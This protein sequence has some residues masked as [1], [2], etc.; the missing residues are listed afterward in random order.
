MTFILCCPLGTADA[1][2]PPL[3]PPAITTG[4]WID[5]SGAYASW[6]AAVDFCIAQGGVDLCPYEVYCPDGAGTAPFN[7][8]RVGRTGDDQW[9]PF[10]GD[11]ENRWVQTGVWGGDNGNT[12]LGHHQIQGGA[13]G[14]PGWGTGN[15]GVA[16]AGYLD[17]VLCCGE[18]ATDP[19]WFDGEE[20]AW[21]GTTWGAGIDFCALKL[22]S[23]ALSYYHVSCF[24][25]C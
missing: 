11:G 21:A 22:T 3:V 7:G 25:Q 19:V 16:D 8:R 14:N 6:G 17:W 15:Q 1:L 18:A 5:T 23:V 9:A 10:G 13:H 12:C 4:D 2:A 24:T 20:P